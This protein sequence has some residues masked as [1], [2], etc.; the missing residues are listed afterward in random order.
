MAGLSPS[1]ESRRTHN[2]AQHMHLRI[3]RRPRAPAELLHCASNCVRERER[4]CE[5]GA[6]GASWGREEVTVQEP[7]YDARLHSNA[8]GQDVRAAVM[9]FATAS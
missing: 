7:K 2:L 4:L 6:T 3:V 1:P 8:T 5:R 9:V